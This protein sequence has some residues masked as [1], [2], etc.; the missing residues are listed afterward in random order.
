MIL[1]TALPHT[2]KS[3]AIKKIIELLGISN[4]G[5][6]YTEEIRENDERVGFMIKT[7]SNKEGVLAHT[8]LQSE[9]KISRYGVDVTKF[10]ELCLGEINRAIN[11]DNI[12]CIIIDEIGPMELFSNRYKELLM[13]L[14]NS[15]KPVIG[16]IYMNSYE[17][18]DDFKKKEGINLIEL[19][20]DNRDQVPHKIVDM[21]LNK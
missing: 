17:W 11:D 21:V 12:K 4:C 6:F 20:L 7:L 9:Y 10:E 18:L 8:N 1:L 3:T 5:G 19:T 14:L 2:G 16:T 13:E 15:K